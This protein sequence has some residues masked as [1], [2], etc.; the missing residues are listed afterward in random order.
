MQKINI[1]STNDL[2]TKG[3][4]IWGCMGKNKREIARE[5]K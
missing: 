5:K 3:T 4:L 1:I 2:L